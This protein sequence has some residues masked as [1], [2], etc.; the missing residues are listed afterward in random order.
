MKHAC[1]IFLNLRVTSYNY[2]F[3]AVSGP[4][5]Q[6]VQFTIAQDKNNAA[7]HK[8]LRAGVFKMFHYCLRKSV[9]CQLISSQTTYQL[10]KMGLIVDPACS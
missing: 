5:S 9:S 8:K 10:E 3:C 4:K 7:Y 1:Y 6:D 2:F